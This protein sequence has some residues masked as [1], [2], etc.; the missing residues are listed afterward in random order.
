MSQ[1]LG[2]PRWPTTPLAFC[3]G[4]QPARKWKKAE[5][6]NL[7]Q[8]DKPSISTQGPNAVGP[9]IVLVLWRQKVLVHNDFTYTIPYLTISH[10]YFRY[11]PDSTSQSL[12]AD[13]ACLGEQRPRTNRRHFPRRWPTVNEAMSLRNPYVSTEPFRNHISRT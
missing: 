4:R 6:S 1:I 5:S 9:F 12:L 13:R 11:T 2:H 10:L 3:A 7:T 8:R